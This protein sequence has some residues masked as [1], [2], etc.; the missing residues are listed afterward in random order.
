MS[1]DYASTTI[2]CGLWCFLFIIIY[3]STPVGER[4]IAIG[5]SVCL[6]VCVSVCLS[7]C[8]SV[9]E[10]ISGS[11][12]PIVTK[13]CVQILCGRGSVLFWPRC[14]TLC[15]SGFVD[16]I[17]FGRN[18]PYGDALPYGV[19]ALWY[20]GGVWCLH[21]ESK[22]VNHPNHGYNYVSSWSICKVFHCCKER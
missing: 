11:D 20:R 19:A 1:N 9:H 12:G 17:T 21:R 10:H 18:G 22:K 13:F 7:V 6:C 4:S 16:D 2:Y 8:L 14:D 5:L 3:Y 15:T